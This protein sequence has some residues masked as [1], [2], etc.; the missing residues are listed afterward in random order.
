MNLTSQLLRGDRKL[1]ACLTSDAAHVLQGANGEHVAKL[2]TALILL[3]GAKIDRQDTTAKIYGSSTAAAVLAY[4]TKRTII[5]PLYQTK[6][7]NIVGKMTIAALDREIFRYELSLRDFNS[8]S[9]KRTQS[10]LR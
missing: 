2:Q 3:D 4:K 9:G 8:C 1:E 10:L 5:N 6:P 7:D